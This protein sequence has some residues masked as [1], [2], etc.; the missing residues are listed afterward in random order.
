[1]R[2]HIQNAPDDPIFALDAG[3]WHAALARADEQPANYTVSFGDTVADLQHGLAEAE[4]LITAVRAIAGRFP[5]P[6]P[7]LK[8][9][10]CTSAGVDKLAPFD[11]LPP[12]VVLM[13]N[14]GTHGAK[15]GE[16]TV[17]ALLMLANQVPRLIAAQQ[18]Q[19]WVTHATSVLAGRRL[20]VIG[21]G[22]LGG[23]AA[24]AAR[25][26]GM[27]IT[28]VRTQAV[29]HPACDRVIA[30]T[31][32]DS[33]LPQT[34]FLVIACPLTPATH[35]LMDRRRL[36][37]L[38]KGAGVIN[39]GRGP[40]LDQDAICDLLEAGDLGGAVLDVFTPEPVPKGHRL[41]TTPNLVMTPHC[42]CDDP[43]TYNPRSLD[44]FFANL[45]A[46]RRGER[47]PNRVDPARGY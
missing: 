24:Q 3:Q 27:D 47:L 26:F 5:I 37:L 14:R 31:A 10:F 33:V 15:A 19:T 1:M 44:L 38:S 35:N 6:A 30:T 43:L 17:M 21:V 46:Y 20:T 16:Y 40:L 9:I 12:G 8:M 32:L 29:P 28:G 18:A 4:V 39:I 2:I 42:S 41:W 34:E 7:A 22:G 23:S 25:L 45:A 36:S 13:N 11:W